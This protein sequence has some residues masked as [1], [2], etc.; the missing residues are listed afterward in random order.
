MTWGDETKGRTDEFEAKALSPAQ[1]LDLEHSAVLG[2]G[3]AR[4]EVDPVAEGA[5]DAAVQGSTGKAAWR[6]RLAPHHREAVKGF[7]TPAGGAKK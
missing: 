7:F 3:A 6:R 5:G 2:V 4:P 1:A